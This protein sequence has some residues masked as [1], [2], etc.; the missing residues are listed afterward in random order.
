MW[1]EKVRRSS[2]KSGLQI[3]LM[4]EM[5]PRKLDVMHCMARLCFQLHV[6]LQVMTWCLDSYLLH[7]FS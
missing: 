1:A 5:F 4:R 7:E 3:Q 6:V 2:W